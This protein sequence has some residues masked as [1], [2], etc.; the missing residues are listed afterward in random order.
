M[1]ETK[2]KDVA[3]NSIWLLLESVIIML[4]SLVIGVISARF[5]GP[6]NYGLINRFIPYISLANSICTFGMQSIITRKISRAQT[7]EIEA[8]TIGSAIRFRFFLSWVAVL[9][10]N[11]YA[12]FVSQDEGTYMFWISLA[13]SVSL[14]FN[15]YEIFTYWFHA[16]LKSKY[17][18]IA[19]VATSVL[20]GGWKI[21]LLVVQ[22]DVIFFAVSTTLQ[23]CLMLVFVIVFFKINFKEKLQSDRETTRLLI[24]DSYHMLLTSLGVA[25]YGQVDKIMIGVQLGNIELGY[26]TAAYTLAT[27][28]YFIPQALSNSMRSV[29]YNSS[30][31]ST[32]YSKKIRFLYLVTLILGVIAGIGFQVLGGFCIRLLYGDEYLGAKAIL[33]VLGWVGVWANIGTVKSIWLVGKGLQKYTKYFTLL[34]ALLNIVLNAILISSIGLVGAA[35]ATLV[36]Q[37]CVQVVFPLFFKECRGAV[38]DLLKC[39]TVLQDV[40]NVKIRLRK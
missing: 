36:S 33:Q 1:Q 22:A 39:F 32:N 18:T 14:L 34:G 3:S 21:V 30:D 31:D 10:I 28:W 23:S 38:W 37:L 7:A 12:F 4:I 24:K 20:V 13:Q 6:N 16:K 29:I 25:I 15:A 35:I 2:V 19:T 40:K 8:K 5:L 17:L 9:L 26:Y 27:L 11:I